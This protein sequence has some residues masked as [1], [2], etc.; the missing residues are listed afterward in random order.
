MGGLCIFCFKYVEQGFEFCLAIGAAIEVRLN[1]IHPRRRIF[2]AEGR[3]GK[4]VEE[5]VGLFAIELIVAGR[6]NCLANG[7][8]RRRRQDRPSRSFSCEPPT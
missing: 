8:K 3:F 6:L 2:A 4:L 1:E 7:D 5:P